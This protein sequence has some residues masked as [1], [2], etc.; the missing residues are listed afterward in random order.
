MNSLS[1]IMS[2]QPSPTTASIVAGLAAKKAAGTLL[3][4]VGVGAAKPKGGLI[5]AGGKLDLS[6]LR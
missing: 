5:G 1:D 4:G 2:A 3:P 6:K